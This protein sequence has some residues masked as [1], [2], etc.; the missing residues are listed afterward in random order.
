MLSSQV[1]TE[2]MSLWSSPVLLVRKKSGEA[3]LCIEY[4]KINALTSHTPLPTFTGVINNLAEQ[5]PTLFSTLD[6]KSG[7]WQAKLD[8]A[9]ADRSA[10][11]TA[12]G[13]F[14]FRRVPFGLASAVSFFQR[15]MTSL[16]CH[17]SPSACLNTSMT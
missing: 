2:T 1:I 12:D 17:L 7:Y 8:P 15:L 10:F 6:L 5:Q 4:R 3:R 13:S 16:L 11:Y 9:T 14:M